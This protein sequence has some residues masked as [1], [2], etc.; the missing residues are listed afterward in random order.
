MAKK[1]IPIILI[2]LLLLSSVAA[3]SN[4]AGDPPKGEVK[5]LVAKPLMTTSM[6]LSTTSTT[7]TGLSTKDL[8]TGLTPEQLVNSLL[9]S[10]VTVTSVKYTGADVAAGTFTGGSDNIGIESGVVLSSEAVSSV[11]GPNQ[12]SATSTNNW[13]SGDTDLNGLIPGYSTNDAASLEFGFIPDSDQITFKYVF[14]SEEY[15]EYVGTQYNDVF[16]FFL[17]GQNVALIPGTSTPVSIHNVN[18]Y[19]NLEYYRNNEGATINT[20]LDGLTTILT[21][22]A[23]VHKGQVNTIKLAV[24]DAGDYILDSDVFIEGG[25]FTSADFFLSPSSATSEI[26]DTHTLTSELKE[27]TGEPIVGETVN[28]K[29]TKGPN[30]GLTGS[31]V[32][33]SDG[34]ATWSYTSSVAGTDKIYAYVG[35]EDDPKYKSNVVTKEW[36]KTSN[37]SPVANAGPDQVVEQ[38]NPTGTSVTSVTL[39]GS[40]STDDG[41]ISP[42]T[43]DW[44]W[45]GGSASGEK[46]VVTLPLGTTTITLTV[47]DG[48]F[49]ST[50]TV[51]V[52]VQDTTPPTITTSGKP[53]VL[54]PPNGKYQTV[55]LSDF[56]ISVTDAGDPTVD[57]SKVVI[58]SVSSDE[59]EDAS[60]VGDGNTLK[61]IVIKD[62]QTV[63]LR[64]ERDGNGNSRVYTINYKVTDASGNTA[65]GS[66]QVWVPH[67]QDTGA[68]AVDDGAA[69]DTQ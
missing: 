12:N 6:G 39:D 1:N 38:A 19:S 34:K 22:T 15:N 45:N 42:L 53:K 64:A 25:S 60:G 14:G 24:A 28:F 20:E 46:P 9:G 61:D 65:T 36:T 54:W 31:N 29:I 50:D 4:R 5:S 37:L 43:Y 48:Q 10:G 40:G 62:P 51:D 23:P 67:D 7:S 17:N 3:A 44:T 56:G 27:S 11:V 30:A 33:D 57:A 21:V 59:F 35:T 58:T 49:S 13:M 63:S 68:T 26:G 18:L 55:S 69:A 47:S 32:T 8:T 2:V 66:S 41:Q 52:T 16:G